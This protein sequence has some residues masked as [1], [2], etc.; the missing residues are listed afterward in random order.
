MGTATFKIVIA[1]KS[2]S[3]GFW[4]VR[5]RITKDRVKRFMNIGIP[6][7]RRHWNEKATERLA[8]WVRPGNHEAAQHNEK[9]QGLLARGRALAKAKPLLTVDELKARMLLPV[10]AADPDAPKE[11]D[12]LDFFKEQVAQDE[13]HYNPT[14][15]DNRRTMVEN[16]SQFTKGTL[17]P[18]ALTLVMVKDFDAWLKKTFDNGPGTR[19]KKIKVLKLYCLRAIRT[20]MLSANPVEGFE[21]ATE[22]PKRVW[23]TEE[24]FAAVEA[25]Q[26][27]EKADLARKVF[28][29]QYYLHGSRVGVVLRLKW[30]DRHNGRITFIPD[31]D[32]DAKSVKETAKLTV[33]LDS[34]LPA[35][36][37]PNPNSYI[38]PY[39]TAAYEKREGRLQKKEMKDATSRV[40]RRLLAVAE[41]AGLKPFSTHVARRTLATLADR[42]LKGD[43][44]AVGSMLGHKSRR[45]TEIYLASMR[46][47]DIDVSADSVYE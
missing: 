39:L 3:D 26:L 8:N 19:N 25:V 38:F 27:P 12:L 24:E 1:A 32:G 9:C 29:A 13:R 45:T 37:K 2:D 31:K 18:T 14:T 11:P 44:G 15:V 47:E 40:N 6:I 20:G 5:L 35:S 43:I 34:L 4:D 28:L 7:D 33:L 16:L 41:K 30:K 36:G 21:L 23:L 10:E 42:K 17:S 46:P 22:R